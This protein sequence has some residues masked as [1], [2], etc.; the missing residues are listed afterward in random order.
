MK[1]TSEIEEELRVIKKIYVKVNED[2][3]LQYSKSLQA[4]QAVSLIR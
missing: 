1:V 3:I 4:Q 2:P